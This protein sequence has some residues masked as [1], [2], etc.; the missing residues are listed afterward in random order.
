MERTPERR[1]R[2]YTSW[3][4]PSRM[5]RLPKGRLLWNRPFDHCEPPMP[6]RADGSDLLTGGL[7]RWTPFGWKQ[8]YD[9]A[10]TRLPS[11]AG[12]TLEIMGTV[13]VCPPLVFAATV[14]ALAARA[15]VPC[16]FCF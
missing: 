7:T 2:N 8:F 5:A 12:G 13:N 6:E 14:R 4:T 9:C 16:G 3:F 10:A 15:A 1:G 11:C